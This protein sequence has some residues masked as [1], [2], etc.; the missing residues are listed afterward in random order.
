MNLT[1]WTTYLTGVF[2]VICCM[3]FRNFLFAIYI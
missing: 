2:F 3:L 1:L